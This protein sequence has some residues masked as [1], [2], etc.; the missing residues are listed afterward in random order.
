MRIRVEELDEWT[1]L[2]VSCAR[3]LSLTGSSAR[4]AEALPGLAPLELCH[5]FVKPWLTWVVSLLR[6][7]KKTHVGTREDVTGT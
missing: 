6:K 4:G 7:N 5:G 3:D 2:H 1:S